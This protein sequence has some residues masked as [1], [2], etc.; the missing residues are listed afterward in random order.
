MLGGDVWFDNGD[1][2]R[3]L[4]TRDTG[5]VASRLLYLLALL[6]GAL[7]GG[8]TPI[9]NGPVAF[10]VGRRQATQGRIGQAQMTRPV[11]SKEVERIEVQ[12]TG[13]PAPDLK[14]QYTDE[15]GHI[16]RCNSDG[17]IGEKYPTL[18]WVVDEVYWCS[19]CRDEHEKG[20]H[21]C[22]ECGEKIEP[23]IIN[24]RPQ[25][26]TKPGRIFYRIDGEDVT[27]EEYEA[28]FAKLEE[29]KDGTEVW[30]CPKCGTEGAADSPCPKGCKITLIGTVARMKDVRDGTQLNV[31][32][33]RLERVRD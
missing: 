15:A 9:D 2:G 8:A 19:D 32:C 29:E 17:E 28:A 31:Q 1:S 11:L 20:H 26:L 16:H 7:D 33:V 24:K 6:Y 12:T 10:M 30:V 27:E 5:P 13:G 4:G 22:K 25:L 3:I 21:E 18:K 23:N 14:W